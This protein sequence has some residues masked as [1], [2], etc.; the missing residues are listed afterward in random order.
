VPLLTEFVTKTLIKLQRI[1]QINSFQDA[2][3]APGNRHLLPYI[4]PSKVVDFPGVSPLLGGKVVVLGVVIIRRRLPLV[5]RDKMVC[6]RPSQCTI[7]RTVGR[8]A[9]WLSGGGRW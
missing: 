6:R 3:E 7:V 9:Y 8:S 1:G 4:L 2:Q 5:W